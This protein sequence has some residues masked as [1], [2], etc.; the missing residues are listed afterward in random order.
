M[1]NESSQIKNTIIPN[2]CQVNFKSFCEKELITKETA[3]LLGYFWAD[4]YCLFKEK[5][6][7]RARYRFVLSIQIEDGLNIQNIINSTGKWNTYI[8]KGNGI[9]KDQ[10]KFE[11]NNY[12]TAKTFHDLGITPRRINSPDKI[13][14]IIP[15]HL[16][17]HFFRGFFDGDGSIYLNKTTRY[18]ITFTSKRNQD[19]SFLINLCDLLNIKYYISQAK[20][21]DASSLQIS[22][23]KSVIK[24]CEYLYKNSEGCRLNRKF[25]KFQDILLKEEKRLENCG[26]F[27]R[28]NGYELYFK[29]RYFGKFKSA[30]EAR[31][32]RNS[33]Y[34]LT[35][36]LV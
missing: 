12:W 26:I 36:L 35:D 1:N 27:K 34:N 29:K 14:S 19:W 10:L 7:S 33:I 28:K 22:S 21:Q 4:A 30:E 13:L 20:N 6:N 25:D 15:D 16:K 3:Y 23:K 8:I 17:H 31:E 5:D 9:R 11:V 32:Y 18:K 2:N 24:F